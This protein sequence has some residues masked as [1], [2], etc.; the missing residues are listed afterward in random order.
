MP[1]TFHTRPARRPRKIYKQLS[2]PTGTLPTSGLQTSTLKPKS[3]SRTSNQM[4]S[5]HGT[6]LV[7]VS[8]SSSRASST[9]PAR[10]S[11]SLSSRNRSGA[12]TRLLQAHI[13]RALAHKQ[14]RQPTAINST[15]HRRVRH[16][17]LPRRRRAY[18]R[19]WMTLRTM[20]SLRE[21]F[22]GRLSPCLP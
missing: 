10:E 7:F 8:S 4:L 20:Y 3:S 1:I 15:R 5:T 13:A 14:V 16:R 21:L 19:S 17:L 11:S 12:N 2:R 9:P 6:S 22:M 18:R